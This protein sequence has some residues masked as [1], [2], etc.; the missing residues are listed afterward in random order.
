MLS[1]YDSYHVEPLSIVSATLPAVP[2]M[3]AWKHSNASINNCISDID[4]GKKA[5]C[6]C[7]YLQL[8]LPPA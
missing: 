2:F 7:K 8:G 3:S 5:E 4:S 1:V 6:K